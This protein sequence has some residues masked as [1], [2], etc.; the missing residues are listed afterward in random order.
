MGEGGLW[1]MLRVASEPGLG[2]P[3]AMG[4]HFSQ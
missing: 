3:K 1:G 2:S 4:G